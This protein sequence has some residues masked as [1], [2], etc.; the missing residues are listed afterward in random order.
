MILRNEEVAVTVRSFAPSE[1]LVLTARG[2]LEPAATAMAHVF[3]D[4]RPIAGTASGVTRAAAVAG[5]LRALAS[6]IEELP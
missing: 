6:I 4:H 5:A 3:W 1:R 2:K